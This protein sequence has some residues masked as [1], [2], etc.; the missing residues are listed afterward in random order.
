M[1]SKAGC[2]ALLAVMCALPCRASL[3]GLTKE[4]SVELLEDELLIVL[5]EMTRSS[6]PC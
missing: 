1:S 6:H 2:N 3:A 5:A 4:S